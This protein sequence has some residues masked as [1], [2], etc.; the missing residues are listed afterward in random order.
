VYTVTGNAS[1]KQLVPAFDTISTGTFKGR[2]DEQARIFTYTV[3]WDSLWANSKKD[4]MTGVK[5]F[6][7]APAATN[8]PLIKTVSL[9]STNLRSS[10]TLGF[11]G[12]TQ[13]SD[14]QYASLLDGKI[15]YIITTIR[16]PNGIIRGQLDAKKQ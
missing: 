8:G 3:G 13:F 14:E 1:S 4:T 16:F 2:Y 10:I 9:T 12:S 11:S 5:F 7:P 6:G 15:Y